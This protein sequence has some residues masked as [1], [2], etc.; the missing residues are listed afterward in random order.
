MRTIPKPWLEKHVKSNDVSIESSWFKKA[1]A[2]KYFPPTLTGE[3]I[4]GRHAGELVFVFGCGPSLLLAEPFIEQLANY[5]SV[6]TNSSYLLLYPDYQLFLD[7]YFFNLAADELLFLDSIVFCWK[8]KKH[9]RPPC[10]TQFTDCKGKSLSNKWAKG[11]RR[12]GASITAFNIAYL[13]GAKEIALLGVDL[14][15]PKHFYTGNEDKYR[16]SRFIREFVPVWD[17]KWQNS[18][19]YPRSGIRF[20]VWDRIAKQLKGRIKVWNCSPN[21]ALGCFE[22]IELGALLDKKHAVKKQYPETE[23]KIA[24]WLQKAREFK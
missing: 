8:N 6:G 2:A 24:E 16:H 17:K 7:H 14:N 12:W 3:E 11:I 18:K 10:F 4:E 15:S 23:K 21:S 22:K 5:T 9:R 19:A 13:F 1:F 20:P